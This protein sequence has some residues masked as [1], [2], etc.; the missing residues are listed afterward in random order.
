MNIS[1][2]ERSAIQPSTNHHDESRTLSSIQYPIQVTIH[3][4]ADITDEYMWQQYILAQ[5]EILRLLETNNGE[6]AEISIMDEL[7]QLYTV[8]CMLMRDSIGKVGAHL[9]NAIYYMF[10]ALY[11]VN[12]IRNMTSRKHT[13]DNLDAKK[14]V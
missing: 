5:F 7:S 1:I 4:P 10:S 2:V 3:N 8:L 6:N 13:Y 12:I 14:R 11:I 9:Y